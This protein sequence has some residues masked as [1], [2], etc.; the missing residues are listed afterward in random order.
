MLRSVEISEGSHCRYLKRC[1]L[2]SITCVCVWNCFSAHHIFSV[3]EEK[4]CRNVHT[5]NNWRFLRK[6]PYLYQGTVLDIM[7]M[8]TKQCCHLSARYENFGIC[9]HNST[10]SS[11]LYIQR[12][13]IM[14]SSDPIGDI[15]IKLPRVTDFYGVCFFV[16]Q[17][18]VSQEFCM[19]S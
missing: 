9:W 19:H 4:L 6:Q 13:L 2:W 10:C 7:R 14:S 16:Y 12:L 3:Y 18:A 11:I 17:M 8:C 15:M 5:L 1:S